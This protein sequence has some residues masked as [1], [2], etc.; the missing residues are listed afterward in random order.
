[1]VMAGLSGDPSGMQV[2]LQVRIAVDLASLHQPLRKSLETASQLGA[3]A[4]QLDARGEI[5]P[6]RLSRTGIR[7]V[8]RLLDD[9]NLRVAA[10]CF[11]TRRG[12]NVAEQLDRRVEVTR[13]VMQLAYDLGSRV[14]TNHVGQVPGKPE[15]PEWDLLVDVLSQL[16]RHGQ[17]VGAMLAA[18]TGSEEPAHMKQLL[19]AL[20]DGLLNVHLD[21][22]Q[23]MIN[24]FSPEESA[25]LLASRVSHVHATDAVRDLARGRGE[26][27]KLGQGSVDFAEILGLL[28]QQ[29]YD[30]YFTVGRQ[31]ATHPV[32]EITEEI[33]YLRAF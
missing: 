8:R 20:P 28:E 5:F 16:G 15:G 18:T 2:M 24:G 9:M 23:L 10:L 1:M 30:G 19:E 27:T 29:G 32:P 14:V 7:H 31:S 17:H 11:R 13:Q 6:G 22:G 33:K 25:T 3:E 21:P 26:E 4:V 12:Y